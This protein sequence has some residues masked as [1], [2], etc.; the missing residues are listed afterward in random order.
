MMHASIVTW[1]DML[2]IHD[3]AVTFSPL[4][5]VVRNVALYKDLNLEFDT[6]SFCHELTSN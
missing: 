6:K 5:I 3:I 1:S 2:I 4:F